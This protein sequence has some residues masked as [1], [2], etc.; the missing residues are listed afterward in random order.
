[1]FLAHS[2]WVVTDPFELADKEVQEFVAIE[3]AKRAKD[4]KN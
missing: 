1:L 2:G 4:K 3:R